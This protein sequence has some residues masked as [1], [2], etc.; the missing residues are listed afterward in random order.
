MDHCHSAV[1]PKGVAPQVALVG[2][3]NAGK[4]VLFNAVTGEYSIVANHP[5]TT[6]VVEGKTVELANEQVHLLDTPGLSALTVVSADERATLQLLLQ[7][8]L[9]GLVFCGDALHLKRSLALLAQLM[10]LELPMVACFNKADQAAAHGMAIDMAGL[11]EVL[12]I[13]VVEVA[14]SHDRGVEQVG[15]R[16]GALAAG[17]VVAAQVK[18]PYPAAVEEVIQGLQGLFGGCGTP[19][20]GVVLL[21]LLGDSTAQECFSRGLGAEALGQAAELLGNFRRRMT[22]VRLQLALFQAREAWAHRLAERVLR[23]ANL[24]IPGLLQKM[25]QASRHPVW[26]WPIFLAIL[27]LT[28]QSVALAAQ[29]LGGWLDGL[30]FAPVIQQLGEVIPWPWL[31]DFLVGQFGILT[32]GVANAM[33]TVVP[34]LL[35]FF[36]IVHFLEDVGYLP[37]LSVLTNRAL[38]FLGL[39]GKAVLPLVLGSGCNTTATMSSRIL[40]TRKERLLVSFLVALG[41]PCSV[42]M[43]ILFAI[44]ASMPFSALLIVLFSVMAT[45]LVCGVAMNRLLPGTGSAGGFILELPLFTWPQGRNIV[46]KT[47]FRIKWFLLEAL[48]MFVAAALVMFTLEKSGLLE[49]IKSWLH[50]L[51]TGFLQLPDKVTEVFILVLARREVG[52]VYFKQMV[53]A[54]ELDYKQIVTGL[55]VITLFIPCMSNT[56]VMIKE[57]GSRWAVVTNLAIIAIA[58]LVGGLVNTLLTLLA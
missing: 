4:S 26:G 9:Q 55:V 10:E 44:L 53:E 7:G 13:P 17:K 51:V 34:I 43:G 48:P 12:G 28:F 39:T 20:R 41:V 36:L 56:M 54:G 45:S 47:W 37:N 49:V 1:R 6:V 2:P 19:S 27:W 24:V 32:M 31:Q 16:I 50:P 23:Q 29:D 42:Q 25:G 3:P 38:S 22:G 35:V 8:G 57:F 14:A 30:I 21:Y 46:R 5:Q 15:S 18:I 58:I 11:Q 33:V 52:A 40:A